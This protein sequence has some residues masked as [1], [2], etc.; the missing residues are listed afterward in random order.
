MNL[1]QKLLL[2]H[3]AFTDISCQNPLSTREARSE[4]PGC[5]C[6]GRGHQDAAFEKADWMSVV[7]EG[8]TLRVVS[9]AVASRAGQTGVRKHASRANM[10]HT[11]GRGAV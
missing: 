8:R 5:S 11:A 10:R 6:S 7:A 1:H 9:T 3:E 4:P 2:L